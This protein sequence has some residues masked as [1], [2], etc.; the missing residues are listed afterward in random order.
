MA[1]SDDVFTIFSAKIETSD[2]APVVTVPERELMIGE[3]EEDEIYRVAILP[4]TR[5]SEPT[6]TDTT[7]S[8]TGATA[9][10]HHQRDESASPVNEGD[11]L[12][13]EIEDVG[14]QGDGIARIGPGY[15]IFV[16]T[17]D[18][19]DRVT[20]RIT[21]ARENFAFSEV[22]EHEPVSD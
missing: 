18:V 7:A 1:L 19:G 14:D 11:T 6:D 20:I 9:S 12:D 22:I 15:I 5:Q 10:R 17:T 21:D 13:V 2:G 16:P 4:Q 8:D 3:L